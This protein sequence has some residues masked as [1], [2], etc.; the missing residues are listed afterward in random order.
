MPNGNFV[1]STVTLVAVTFDF[2][3]STLSCFTI[4]EIFDMPQQQGTLYIGHTKILD[5][6]C[7]YQYLRAIARAEE[8]TRAH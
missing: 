5:C 4:N 7:N 1:L 8:G 2:I 3:N 6:T